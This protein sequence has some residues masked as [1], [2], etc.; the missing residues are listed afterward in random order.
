M[1]CIAMG[2]YYYT[3]YGQLVND[4]STPVLLELVKTLMKTKD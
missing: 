4:H 1:Q 3:Y 2:S